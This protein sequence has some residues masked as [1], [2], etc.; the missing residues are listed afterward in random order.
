M[1]NNNLSSAEKM[2]DRQAS[3]ISDRIS[4]RMRQAK[5][6]DQGPY[7]EPRDIAMLACVITVGLTLIYNADVLAHWLS[8]AV[9]W[10]S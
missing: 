1:E 10:F 5:E 6:F 3:E 7:L 2:I 8:V 4:A 9:R